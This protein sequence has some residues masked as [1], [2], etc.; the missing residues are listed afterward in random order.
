M[1]DSDSDDIFDKM[2][3]MQAVLAGCGFL[4]V[5]AV[6]GG[7]IWAAVRIWGG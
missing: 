5:L 1:H 3:K 4:T 6:A 7:L 2:L